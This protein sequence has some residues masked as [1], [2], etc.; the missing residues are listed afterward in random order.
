MLAAC[1]GLLLAGCA[2][3]AVQ[4]ASAGSPTAAAPVAPSPATSAPAAPSP[5]SPS[6]STAAP[7]ADDATPSGVLAV[8]DSVMLGSKPLLR[9]SG[10]RVVD[11]EVGRQFGSAVSIVKRAAA[12]GTLPRNV[13]V[14]LGTNGT[15]TLKACKGV[16]RYAGPERKVFL[17]TVRVPRPWQDSNNRTLARCASA[18]GDGRAEVVDWSAYS[19]GH[20]GWFGADRVHPTP[21]GRTHYTELIERTVRTDG[22]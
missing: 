13:V 15:V 11:A 12:R 21:T 8:G 16:V 9:R 3:P 18:Y 7:K 20:P 10:V 17:V 1:A 14:H 4:T 6:P 2:A 22:I 19:A 5:A